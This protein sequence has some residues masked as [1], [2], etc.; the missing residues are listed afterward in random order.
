MQ[1]PFTPEQFFAVFAAYNEAVWP[2]QLVLYAAA[3]LTLL[4]VTL[5]HRTA[6]GVASATLG[7]LWAWIGIAYHLAFF[8]EINPL[9]Y[10]FAL[11]SLAGAGVFAWQGIVRRRLHFRW[12]RSGRGVFG[13]LLIVFALAVYPLWTV[14]SG[15]AYPAMPTFGLP[16]PTTLFTIGLL[17]LLEAPYPRAPLVV[18][19]LW[20]L[21]GAQAAFLLDV[22][23][24]LSLLVA[25][26]VAIALLV[27]GRRAAPPQA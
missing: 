22:P 26:A 25:A 5:R 12:R 8:A 21:V 17:A 14:A 19:L 6:D 10:G 1:L 27:A 16:C 15:H 24:D 11:V 18:P 23:A 20:S 4:A 13:A 3:L 9:A 7:L 2:A